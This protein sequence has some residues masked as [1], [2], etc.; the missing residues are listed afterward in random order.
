[1]ASRHASSLAR[2]TWIKV[3]AS[4]ILLGVFGSLAMVGGCGSDAVVETK[5]GTEAGAEGGGGSSSS[6][7]GATSSSSGGVDA[8]DGG[9]LLDAQASDA[10]CADASGEIECAGRCGPVKDPCTGKVKQCGGCQPVLG[11]ADGGV[12]EAR[13]CDLATNSC[14]KPLVNCTQLGAE[15][16]TLKNS[17]GDYLDCP[18]GATK[19]CP[20]GKECDPDTNKCRD[21]RATTCQ[22]LGFECG[23]AWLG[24]GEDTEANRT[25]CGQCAPVNGVNRVCN[26]VF[27]V[28]EPQCT[29][30]SALEL[31]NDAKA[32][33]G[34]ECGVISN[35]CG[36][37]V[38]CDT[39]AGFG[40]TNGESCGVRGI[41]NR[42][43][44]KAQ[45]DECKALGKTCGTVKSVCS[46]ATLN[47]GDCKVGEVCNANG[48]CGPPCAA[49]TCNDF[50]Q[51]QCGTFDDGCG[52]TLKCGSCPSGVCSAN[53]TCCNANTCGVT[54]AG[55]CGTNL[56]NGCGANSV[57]CACAA[58][59]ACTQ[60]GAATPAPANGTTGLCCTRKTSATFTNAGQCGTNLP[61]GCGGTVNATC[62]AGKE[63]VANLTGA[64][65][66]APA[67]GVVGT[68]CTRTDTCNSLAADTCGPVQNSCR[69][70]GTTTQCNKCVAPKT[71]NNNT[72]CCQAA[73]ACPGG[74]GEGAECNTV[75][76]PV[77]VGCGS[78][79][80]CTCAGG[81][82]CWCGNKVC[83]AGD[84]AGACK[85]K[86]TCA[87]AYAGK[88]G[89]GLSDGVGGT[90]NCGCGNGKVC[91]TSA[92]G[93]EGTCQCNTPNGQA[94][95]CGTVPN[96]PGQPG[97]DAC[98]SFSDGCGGTLNC[99]CSN[100]QVC[101][102]T[103]NPNACCT[104]AVC[105]AQGLGSA[106][107]SITNGC[108]G[109]INCG[110]PS[111]AA[112]ANFTCTA[113]K[114]ACVKDTCRGRTG[115]QPDLC[116]GT[117]SCGG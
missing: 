92:P 37:T 90:L 110:C 36:G 59:Q 113:G 9:A 1:M 99:G 108:G 51:F 10:S 93:Q 85:S 47:C 15:C 48:V 88:C 69:P 116:G 84:P 22:E 43:D 52:G 115:P 8:G 107:G 104:P 30:K 66:P 95:T 46:G 26:G 106:C 27:R 109:N 55:K 17:C 3:I 96:G 102:T 79:R 2:A 28:C 105:P 32:K 45:P 34:L 67:S 50:S 18:E 20:A 74:G 78:N 53:N 81:R 70:A 49:K 19:G 41:A 64:A 29:P 44:R 80:S 94:Y 112:N 33:K 86:L 65:G 42:C 54:F 89:T 60:D 117:L 71:C 16:G 68:C 4:C 63:C 35:G 82:V 57:T 61:D 76:V 7:S 6:S 91:S 87:G 31:C 75:K 58:G 103:P 114:C 56:A 11:G 24:C 38:N 83:G 97:G 5:E 72:T 100:G 23:F 101:N 77:D 12:P 62:G 73:P 14:I 39:V 13:V 111:G 98:G 25:D 40:C 21:C